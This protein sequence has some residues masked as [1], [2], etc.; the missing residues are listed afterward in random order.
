MMG[1]YG[2]ITNTSKTQF[3]FDRTYPNRATME[4]NLATD[5]IYTGRYVLIEYDTDLSKTLDTFM[6]VYISNG[7]AYTA[8]DFSSVSRLN[9]K[10]IGFG[11]I[12]F[13]SNDYVPGQPL[14]PTDCIFWKCTSILD[15][16]SN[17]PATF[18][19][20]VSSESNYVMNFNI[21]TAKYG[22][23]R[24]Y[25]STVWQ[26][27]Y[28]NNMEK[29]VQIAELNSV[30]PTF[31]ISAD[32]PT[33][34]PLTP[35][36]DTN[37]TNVYYK[38][39]WQPTWGLRVRSAKNQLGPEFTSE[40]AEIPDSQIL[41]SEKL[42]F[43]MNSDEMTI[44][45]RNEYNPSTGIAT[46]L[47]W[48]PDKQKWEKNPSNI[49]AA[50]YYNKA[51]FSS[52]KISIKDEGQ[53]RINLDP[54]G[55]SGHRYNDHLG[56]IGQESAQEDIQEL[57]IMLPSIGNSIAKMWNI[58]YGDFEQNNSSNTRNRDISWNSYQGLRMVK[59][60]KEG[61]GFTYE[62][63][64]VETLAGAIN[65]VHDLMGMIIESPSGTALDNKYAEKAN[66]NY[67][68]YSDGKYWRKAI[69][70]DY[71]PY[72]GNEITADTEYTEIGAN[73]FEDF[74]ANTFYYSNLSGNY[75]LEENNYPTL[76]RI[77]YTNATNQNA[78]VFTPISL[79]PF[80]II[81][82]Q[83]KRYPLYFR[84]DNNVYTNAEFSPTSGI[85]YWT[86]NAEYE[87]DSNVNADNFTDKDYYI[88]INGNWERATNFVS[89]NTYYIKINKLPNENNL[90][91][92][93]PYQS[94]RY[95]LY[96]NDAGIVGGPIPN[97]LDPNKDLLSY[98]VLCEDERFNPNYHYYTFTINNGLYAIQKISLFAI[99]N[100]HFYKRFEGGYGRCEDNTI[101]DV[102]IHYIKVGIIANEEIFNSSDYYI[103][104]ET[105]NKYIRQYVW[106]PALTY[107]TTFKVEYY[108][109]IISGPFTN[110]Y[111]RDKYYTTLDNL[112]YSLDRNGVI[113]ENIQY[114]NCAELATVD[115]NGKYYLGNMY[116]YKENGKYLLDR[117][118]TPTTNRTY[119]IKNNEL[120]V[121]NDLNNLYD[122]GCKW[123]MNI[124]PIPDGVTLATRVAYPKFEELSGFARTLNTIHGLILKINH[125]LLNGDLYTRDQST[126]QGCINVLNDIIAKFEILNPGEFMIVDNYGRIHSTPYT[127]AQTY[128]TYNFGK[129]QSNGDQKTIDT[130]KDRWIKLEVDSSAINPLITIN[131]EFTKQNNTTTTS[132]KN[133]NSGTGNNTG[134]ND[135]LKLYTP[136]VDNTGHVVGN[137]IETVTLPYGYKVISLGAQSTEL[138]NPEVN[139]DSIIADTTQDTLNIQSDNKWI[140]MSAIPSTK[141][142]NIGHE[143]H[144][145]EAGKANTEYGL[146]NSIDI[147]DLNSD[148]TF[149]VPAFK[150]DEA[151]HITMAKINTVTIPTYSLTTGK[152][153]GTI[154]F[155]GEDIAV[156]GL[157]S[158]AY[159]NSDK[160]ADA[161][162]L[163][164]TTFIY[165]TENKTIAELFK[166]VS[167][168]TTKIT[169][170]TTEL[171]ELKNKVDAEHPTTSETEG[172]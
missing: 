66:E 5:G 58:I 169:N 171:N 161:N 136:I 69:G 94:K 110:F 82:D 135:D 74:P 157:G 12:V 105:E 30:V 107:Y 159:T 129:L 158:A 8:S 149:E 156:K 2:N 132:N 21:D 20:V 152:Q 95:Y 61:N 127:T 144:N 40:G 32:A 90:I 113:N 13:T 126:V 122:I 70:Y 19:R 108:N 146:S 137:N 17:E 79:I 71:I 86:L 15:K 39:H 1:F 134:N 111:F 120:Y 131:H 102:G 100:N 124:S 166:I 47:Y 25:D 55:K 85:Q 29:Y 89:G 151:G 80:T 54:I 73:S 77:Y 138:N 41:Y 38:L 14:V 154:A 98:L 53:D 9:K 125:L 60:D 97:N 64:Q 52:E 140:R 7:M 114:Y 116:Y 3:Q 168:L 91:T 165:G 57:S 130:T 172:A 139:T 48:N 153:Q 164:D 37:S 141:T 119:Y 83:E 78:E 128:S 26:K 49:D 106:D 145:F 18:A 99:T 104:N 16:N 118:N 23:S 123:N 112:T 93:T 67:I 142:L 59:N 6:R 50:I 43:P 35:H 72:Q 11:D 28:V 65:S 75:T 155:N 150:F 63:N 36:F 24:G 96:K 87:I 103:Y 148:N 115:I 42:Q 162:I 133:N 33:Q 170:L 163:N 51:G 10:D 4:A 45:K 81:D 121:L 27:V 109:F 160:Y 117:N 101:P 46:N 76:N 62:P 68:Y 167:D 88:N 143:V 147:E 22:E 44:W 84:N 31:D 92:K 56:I 34:S